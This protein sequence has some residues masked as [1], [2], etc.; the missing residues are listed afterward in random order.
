M[1]VI[2]RVYDTPAAADGLRVLVDRLWP[3]GLTKQKAAVNLWR[4]D[5]APSTELRKWFGHDPAKWTEFK[6]RYRRELGENNAAIDL[7][8]RKSRHG[9][10]TLL[11][12]AKDQEHNEALLLH[13]MLDRGQKK[14]MAGDFKVGDHVEWNSE[15]GRVRGTIRKKITAKIQFKG[16]A[17]HA[18]R[19]EP[20]YLIDS[21]KTDHIAM[22]KGSALKRINKRRPR[23][24]AKGG[25]KAKGASNGKNKSKVKS[26][27]K[28]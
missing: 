3:R 25:S 22:H 20:Q 9:R 8:R 14:S 7:L 15:A 1:I 4:K 10:I 12:G 27:S 26:K 2:K 13:R 17:V 11:Y 6:K 24:N 19:E 28:P 16:Y 21:D 23:P 18:S 5:I